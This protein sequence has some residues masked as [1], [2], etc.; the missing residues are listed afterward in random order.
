MLPNGQEHGQ[1]KGDCQHFMKK[2]PFGAFL[3][4][5]ITCFDVFMV[6]DSTLSI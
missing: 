4:N 2:A 1:R 5:L 6:G 3:Y